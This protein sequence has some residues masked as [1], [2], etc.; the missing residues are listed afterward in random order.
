MMRSCVCMLTYFLH[1]GYS[2]QT[3]AEVRSKHNANR[4]I[5]AT[6]SIERGKKCNPEPSGVKG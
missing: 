4:T 1:E 3:Q 2:M 6:E 5:G